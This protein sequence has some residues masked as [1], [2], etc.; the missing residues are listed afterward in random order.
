MSGYRLW[1]NDD[2]TVL[3]HLWEDG[4][5]EVATRPQSQYTWGP[6]VYLHETDPETSR[7][8]QGEKR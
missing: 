3:V 6:P 4:K 2:S 7:P 1:V 5:M 8:I